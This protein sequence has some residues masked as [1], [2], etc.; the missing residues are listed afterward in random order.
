MFRFQRLSHGNQDGVV[1]SVTCQ[2]PYVLKHVLPFWCILY[3]L[4]SAVLQFLH[5]LDGDG[6]FHQALISFQRFW[7]SLMLHGVASLSS[8]RTSVTM[9]IAFFERLCSQCLLRGVLLPFQDPPILH[10][11]CLCLFQPR[12]V[13]SITF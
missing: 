10:N 5:S 12:H 13:I 6:E 9:S 4:K 11:A 1:L 3:P 8:R 7:S 2:T